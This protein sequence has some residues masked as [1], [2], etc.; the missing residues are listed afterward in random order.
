MIALKSRHQD[1][2]KSTKLKIYLF[3]KRL[4]FYNI[5]KNTHRF[6]IVAGIEFMTL[7]LSPL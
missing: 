5:F 3:A 2:S 1:I 7:R 6:G 4:S